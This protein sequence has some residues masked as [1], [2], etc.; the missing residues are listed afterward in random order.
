MSYNK[1]KP[2]TK[3]TIS[4]PFK[5]LKIYTII[6]GLSL[7]NLDIP[8]ELRV[9][10]SLNMDNFGVVVITLD[11]GKSIA[12]DRTGLNIGITDEDWGNIPSNLF[13]QT[14]LEFEEPQ[15]IPILSGDGKHK[16]HY[17]SSDAGVI[18]RFIKSVPFLDSK[19]SKS[20]NK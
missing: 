11:S 16:S 12:I 4:T 3:P 17:S 13:S 10:D 14:R 8:D 15:V 7:K 1:Q 9:D 20:F 2:A 19:F 6:G 18:L 5:T